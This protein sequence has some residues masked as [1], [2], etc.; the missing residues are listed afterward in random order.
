MTIYNFNA[1]PSALPQEVI[2]KAQKSLFNFENSGLSV[3]EMSHRSPMYEEIH[4]GA[5][6]SIKEILNIPDDFEILLLQGGASMQFAMLPMN[7]LQSEQ[8]AAYVLSGSWSEK[9][10]KEAGRIGDAYVL[11]SSKEDNYK[12]IPTIEF[13]SVK[14][15]TS[16]IHLTSN[17][18]IFGTQWQELPE[19][20]RTPI[21]VDASSDIFSKR[22][23]WNNVDVLYAGAQK[24][25]GPSGV[26]VVIMRKTLLEQSNTSIPQILT[27][28]THAKADS[29]YHTPPTGSIYVLGLVMNW[30]KENGGIEGMESRASNKAALLYDVIDNSNQ[31][32]VG[33]ALVN[34]RSLMNVTFRLS[35]ENLEKKFLQEAKEFGFEGVKGHRSVG[36][37]RASIYNAVPVD[38]VEKLA[39][40]MKEFQNSH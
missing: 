7:F 13:D 31:F 8:S 33:H 3:M 34:S 29:L 17:N 30:I 2:E 37:C 14:E 28:N 20:Q 16:Y 40:F 24:N 18:T 32:Y 23:N 22:I 1:G 36:G 39:H 9:A 21:F 12:S 4:F 26:T 6:S 11:S 5:I 19:K 35:D 10:L 25:A 38:H 15:N 27:Y